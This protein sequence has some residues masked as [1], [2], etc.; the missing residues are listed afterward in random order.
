MSCP[1]S[2]SINK[3]LSSCG[4]CVATGAQRDIRLGQRIGV[5][6]AF[7]GNNF[8]AELA[9]P[10]RDAQGRIAHVRGIWW[11]GKARITSAAVADPVS[12]YNLRKLLAQMTLQDLSGWNYWNAIDARSLID[13]SYTRHLARIEGPLDREHFG[14]QGALPVITTDVDNV[15]VNA[16]VTADYNITTYYPLVTLGPQS[17]PLEGLIP[18][19]A[20][21]LA[22]NGGLRF[23]FGN[24][25]DLAQSPVGVTVDGYRR[26]NGD[27]GFDLWLDIVYLPAVIADEAWNVNHYTWTQQNGDLPN[28]DR[29]TEQLSI[30]YLPEDA[31]LLAGQSLCSQF[32]SLQV[33]IAGN[34]VIPGWQ[35]PDVRLRMAAFLGAN[36]DGASVRDNAAQDLPVFGPTGYGDPRIEFILPFAA[37]EAS[38]AGTVHFEFTQRTPNFTRWLHRTV[39][40]PGATGAAKRAEMLY[41][42]A[43]CGPCGAVFGCDRWGDRT[44]GLS[45]SRPIVMQPAAFLGK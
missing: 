8:T 2:E 40:C 45:Q 28:G 12:A 41:A 13:D 27:P 3:A 14:V 11:A 42:A 22:M 35:E 20:I 23:R 21:Q 17:N 26:V 43:K 7:P 32:G 31:A 4:A 38:A 34:N 29:R 37:R 6:Q 36:R 18:L 10:V 39:H 33:D 1:V 15:P 9:T 16:N 25:A 30:R 44:P 24:T 19:A 5:D